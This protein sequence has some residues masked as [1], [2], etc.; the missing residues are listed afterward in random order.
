VFDLVE[1]LFQRVAPDPS[2]GFYS[3]RMVQERSEGWRMRQ[4][5]IFPV[6]RSEDIGVMVTAHC[7]GGMGYAATCDLSEQSLTDAIYRARLWSE[8][9]AGFTC[10]D[11][12]TLRMP[13]PRGQFRSPVLKP[14][15][16]VSPTDRIQILR[17]AS[18]KLRV[19]EAIVD[20]E[21]ELWFV[22]WHSLYLTNGQGRVEQEVDLLFPQL[23]ATA[24]RASETQT[25]ST[26]FALGQ[27]GGLEVLSRVNFEKQAA[28]LGTEAVRLLDA[29]NCPSGK[30]DVVLMPDQMLLQIHESV[31]HPLEL[32]R[33]IGDERNYAGTSFVTLDMFGSYP[34]GSELLNVVFDPTREGELACYGWDDDGV[35]AQKVYVIQNG[36]L[37]SP[38]GSIVSQTRANIAGTASARAT[39]WNRPPIDRMSNLNVEPGESSLQEL[40]GGV[41][42]GV[43]MRSNRSWSI[44]DS[45]NKFQF[46]C[47]IGQLIENGQLKGLVKNPNY[48]GISASFWRS[49]SGVGNAET[50]EAL[51][52]PSCGKGEPNQSIRVGHASPACRFSAVD[53]FGGAQ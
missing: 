38:L 29:P 7:G 32:D 2:D 51:G 40:I 34:Y 4:G 49:L 50:F 25:R 3:F 19:S 5:V 21:A 14:W 1:R 23:S 39:G 27:Q 37:K 13:H 47:E 33:I 30:L 22:R 24:N 42:R 36:I 10:V 35:P 44:D 48:R 31:G 26:R 15:E 18:E 16:T 6:E 28:D 53:V 52:T 20:W 11:T 41:E 12:R 8:R 9:T 45:R 46:G 17:E 43:L